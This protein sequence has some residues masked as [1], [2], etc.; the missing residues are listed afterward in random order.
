MY[1]TRKK[2]AVGKNSIFFSPR[3]YFKLHYK[4][5]IEPID[6]HSQVVFFLQIMALS[7]IFFKKG[8]GDLPPSP[9]SYASTSTACIYL[10]QQQEDRKRYE[11]CSK[12]TIK[13]L[14]DVPSV[15]IV[16]LRTDYIFLLKLASYYH[17]MLL[18]SSIGLWI[19]QNVRIL[20]K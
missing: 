10:C 17:G 2:G 8:R 18:Y 13:K 16:D 20:R 7:S 19:M 9:S 11:V 3:N 1:N 5:E 15:F 12:L 14:E 6:D 4:R